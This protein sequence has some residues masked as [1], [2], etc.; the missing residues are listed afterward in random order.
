MN[1]IRRISPLALAAVAF[2]ACGDDD[3]NG[4]RTDF[5]APA[6]IAMSAEVRGITGF[7]T[8]SLRSIAS[9]LDEDGAA[10]HN[11]VVHEQIYS[12]FTHVRVGNQPRAP[13]PRFDVRMDALYGDDRI[14]TR[15]DDFDGLYW[16]VDL[17]RLDRDWL[18]DWNGLE[19]DDA[20]VRATS[21]TFSIRDADH[22]GDYQE[23]SLERI[24]DAF[25]DADP[26]P[27]SVIIGSEMERHYAAAP[28]DWGAFADFVGDVAGALRAIDPEV[29]VG[30]GVN[31]SNFMDDVVPRFVSAAGQSEVNFQAVRAAW[32]AV[33]DPLYLRT[34]DPVAGTFE[35]ALDFY[36]FS[37]VP[38][39]T[40]YTS[41]SALPENHFSG[42]A[43][44]FAEYP[45]KELPVAWFAVGWP[46]NGS[47]SE[48]FGSY[49]DFFVAHAGGVDVEL[50]AWWGYGHLLSDSDCRTMTDHV[51]LE[52]SACYHGL[53]TSSGSAVSGLRDAYFTDGVQ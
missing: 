1:S 46:V 26:R 6:P 45:T 19:R 38:D 16:L 15:L 7:Y 51:G 11:F 21:F 18:V 8:D 34:V 28:E 14:G 37:A 39:T 3:G 48:F 47:S 10:A 29:R 20:D 32:E 52:P 4:A 40:R 44:F 22:D 41:P 36:A 13:E 5:L 43:T 17:Q 42:P 31:W 2:V 49:W 30:V 23:A 50:V 27:A 9:K 33:L 25:E 12:E 53:Y 35:T 24:V